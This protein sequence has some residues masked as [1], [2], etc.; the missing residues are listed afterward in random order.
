VFVS[1]SSAYTNIH[2]FMPAYRHITTVAPLTQLAMAA[3]TSDPSVSVGC[4]W[5]VCADADADADSML[6]GDRLMGNDE[7]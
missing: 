5:C 3:L 1:V 4:G 6:K 7:E 2:T